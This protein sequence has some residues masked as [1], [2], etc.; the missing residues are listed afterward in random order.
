MT[1]HT[2]ELADL[3]ETTSGLPLD[4]A[5]VTITGSVFGFNA[6][7]GAG[8]T[9]WNA[10]FT[11]AEGESQEQSFSV[12][13][14]GGEPSRDGSELVNAPKAFSGRSNYGRMIDSAREL[15]GSKEK[16]AE[17]IGDPRVADNWI[18]TEWT[19]G[20]IKEPGRMNP[21]T[22]ERMDKDVLVFVEFHGKE[23][24]KAKASGA[25]SA[26]KASASASK[27]ATKGVPDDIE[28]ELWEQLVALAK[29]H[30]DHEDFMEAAL[31]LEDV[32]NSTAAQRAVIS[33]RDGG[34]WK[35]AHG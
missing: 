16:C 27:S 32:D 26:S 14:S 30:D 35:A 23:G 33:T 9:C 20:T 28:P 34:V 17:V 10:T 11:T 2:D 7:I 6:N 25:K 5:R 18:G 15:L 4:G 12:G 29:E 24:T 1:T 31:A 21:Q 19:L 8:V 13:Q 3:W 22:K